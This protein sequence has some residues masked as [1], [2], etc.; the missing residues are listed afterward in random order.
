MVMVLM[1]VMAVVTAVAVPIPVP[2]THTAT[3]VV[4]SQQRASV[5]GESQ[6]WTPLVRGNG[7]V[8]QLL[9]L[10]RTTTRTTM[11]PVV[12]MVAVVVAAAVVVALS[13]L[14]ASP[15]AGGSCCQV[16]WGA[17][18]VALAA[19][20]M[21]GQ[22]HPPYFGVDTAYPPALPPPSFPC[23]PARLLV[24]TRSTGGQGAP[25]C[26][27]WHPT[28][29]SILRSPS[30]LPVAC[31]CVNASACGWP[32]AAVRVQ[33]RTPRVGGGPELHVPQPAGSRLRA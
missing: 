5:E 28:N 9:P 3:T 30:L 25:W 23:T 26:H 20:P 7:Q 31:C 17:L 24:G 22:G 2:V 4:S 29:S 10:H 15:V 19:G 11:E 18:C 32:R 27:P 12:L 33:V 6:P 8:P 1:V 21:Q 14:A 16:C 13:C